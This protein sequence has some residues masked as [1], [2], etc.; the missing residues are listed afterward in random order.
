MLFC[1]GHV[2]ESFPPAEHLPVGTNCVTSPKNLKE[3]QQKLNN[4]SRDDFTNLE[5][6]S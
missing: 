1:A 2:W 6:K 3:W 4:T 5:R